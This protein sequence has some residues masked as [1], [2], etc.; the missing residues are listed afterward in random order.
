MHDGLVREIV[1]YV[2]EIHEALNSIISKSSSASSRCE[3]QAES[4]SRGLG[5]GKG[6]LFDKSMRARLSLL[7]EHGQF[8]SPRSRSFGYAR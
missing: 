5:N 6:H 3:G 7:S 2:V 8:I 1:G 4:E